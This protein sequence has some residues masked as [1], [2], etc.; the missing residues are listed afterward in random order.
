[1]INAEQMSMFNSD[2]LDLLPS[3]IPQRVLSGDLWALGQHKL[4]CG[5]STNP[6]DVACLMQGEKAQAIITDPP[7][8]IIHSSWDK[9]DLSFIPSMSSFHEPNA[10][11]A[12]FCQLPFGFA[13]HDAMI[14]HGY[15][16]RWEIVW[17]KANGGFRVSPYKPR[18]CH[19]LIFAYTRDAS[20]SDLVF[21]GWDAGEKGKPWRKT[22]LS[23]KGE[24]NETYYKK[25]PDH[26]IGHPDGQ[27]WI[28]S[29]IH[30][31]R[32][33]NMTEGERTK[34]P[35]QKPL[36]IL[37]ALCVTLSN[38]D[39]IILDLFGG[40]GTALIAAEHTKRHARIMEIS[41]D[42]CDLILARWEKFTGQHAT[43]IHRI[44]QEQ[45]AV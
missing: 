21:N 19:E 15:D 14:K 13:L 8:G 1:L 40:S 28:R 23:K 3:S 10:T 42:Y 30:G 27:R 35:T 4:Y 17:V 5:D 31:V 25:S 18:P 6:R 33:N 16:W 12:I 37:T 45:E 22:N 41:S 43:L 7:Y 9:I 39:D 20:P 2:N 26:S 36:E 11:I 38:Q 34:H 29:T 44:E 32:K 24:T